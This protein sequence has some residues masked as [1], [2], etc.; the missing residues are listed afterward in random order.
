MVLILGNSDSYYSSV[1]ILKATKL[2]SFFFKLYSFER[3]REHEEG[4][5]AEGE[6][7]A[8][9]P[10]SW[11]PDAGLHPRTLAEGRCLTNWGAPIWFML[12][13]LRFVYLKVWA[14]GGAEGESQAYPPLS[15]EHNSRAQ[16]QDP[17]IMTWAKAKS[18]PLNWLS[19]SGAAELC[20][21]SELILWSGN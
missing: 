5:R 8:G 3:K 20:T 9:S 16:S 21:L 10:L 7:E 14:G 1:D 15:A 17:E 2:Y 11:E 12:F 19:H 6:G 18:W 13:F 4:R